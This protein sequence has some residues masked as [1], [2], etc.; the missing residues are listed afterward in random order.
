[1]R[2][3]RVL[4]ACQKALKVRDQ[5]SEVRGQRSEVRDQRSER[6]QP[7]T[8][9]ENQAVPLFDR[10]VSADQV[11]IHPTAVVDDEVTIG[12]KTRIWHFSHILSGSVI[13]QSCNI[14]QNVVI[15]PRAQ[16]GKGCK[17]QNNISI[18]EGVTL[19]DYVFCGPSV[20]FTNV[21]NPRAEIPRMKELRTTLVRRGATLGAN[22]TIV[23]GVTIGRY[24]FL[25]AG[26][27]VTKD[28]PDHALVVGNPAR[29]I[30]W[31]CRCGERL[32]DDLVCPV[33]GVAY[34]E[35]EKGLEPRHS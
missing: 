17:I 2:V 1:L 5:K 11:F 13:G 18:Y 20:V 31:M 21:F 22:C 23:C 33:C 24:A 14:G 32:G 15:G 19:E 6:R 25:G 27:I 8:S 9:N 29:Q 28:V 35:S 34:K 10:D 12:A 26:A 16:I 30:G 4:N 7:V 3:L